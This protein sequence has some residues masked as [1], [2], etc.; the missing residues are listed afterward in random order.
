MSI[1]LYVEDDPILQA[2]GS[3]ALEKS[4]Y[5][6]R[7]ACDGAQACAMLR[8]DDPPADAL[9]TDINLQ[10]AVEGW[11]VAEVGRVLDPTLAVVY[12]SAA[13]PAEFV[14]KGVR[15]SVWAAKPFTW[16]SVLRSVER[17]LHP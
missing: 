14:A 8:S 6:V 4:G 5:E 17:L 13:D 16:P 10:G 11:Q 7:S 9:I 1:I 12:T 15:G 3:A 2:D